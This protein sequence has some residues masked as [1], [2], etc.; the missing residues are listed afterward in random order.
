[1]NDLISVI[2][3]VYKV[4]QYLPKCIDS[5]L[6]QT[7][8]NLEI[9]LVDDGSP[10]RCGQICDEYAAKDDRIHVIHK[11]NGGLSDARNAAL[12]ICTGE[13]ISFIDSDD[14]VSEDFIESLY[15]ATQVHQTKLAICGVIRFDEYGNT[16]VSYEP[17]KTEKC[18]A[19][20]EMF[21]TIWQPS[22]CNKLYH[23]S[24]FEAIRYPYGKL[25]EDLFVY[26]DILA[27]IDRA[28]LTGK[29]SYFYYIRQDSIMNKQ[30]D[31]RN[32]D[33]IEALDLRICKLR[34][35]NYADLAN[36]QLCFLF[37][38]TVKAFCELKEHDSVAKDRLK[39]VK[40]I[41]DRHFAEILSFKGFT[42][43]QKAKAALFHFSPHIY[44]L[45]FRSGL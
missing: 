37:N 5:I 4:E 36:R 26:H 6:V 7:Y 20:A 25:Y 2:I 43:P 40:G 11:Q 19:G 29:N 9:L 12:D 33:L 39:Y 45:F 3:P 17:S 8:T 44:T 13:Y 38:E 15:H 35:L 32:T 42:W 27:Q 41:S 23:K 24:L 30:F 14:Y 28:S 1:M 10:D 18:V 34:A 31:L 16:S 21:E 22:A